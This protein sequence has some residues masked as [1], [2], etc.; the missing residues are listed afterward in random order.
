M[1]KILSTILVSIV[2]VLSACSGGMKVDKSSMGEEYL[3][4]QQEILDAQ[5]LIIKEDPK[6]LT[7]LFEAAFRY[8]MLGEYGDAIK[9]YEEVLVI[10]ESHFPSLNNLAD[11]YE[12]LED[13]ENSAKY[14]KLLYQKNPNMPEVIKDTVRIL[15]K[16][17]D[18]ENAQ[19]ALENFAKIRRE[20]KDGSAQS[21][22]S[23]LFESINNHNQ[24]K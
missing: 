21:L 23:E 17:N 20:S 2:F 4:Q 8:Q 22:I 9:Y 3:S 12:E 18:S 1:K 10:D 7:A 16:A 24:A 6:N 5:L 14:I 19:L 13:Y 11:M 15:L